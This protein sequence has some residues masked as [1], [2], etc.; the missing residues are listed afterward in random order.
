MEKCIVDLFSAVTQIDRRYFSAIGRRANREPYPQLTE[1]S[2]SAELF[3]RFKNI[4]ELPINSEYYNNLI[5]HY[6]ITKGHMNGRPDLVLHQAQENTNDQRLLIEVKTD[7]GADLIDDLN[8]LITATDNYLHF[9]NVALIIVNR[10][11]INTKQITSDFFRILD[12]ERR[13][14]IFLINIEILQNNKIDY[15]LFQFSQILV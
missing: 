14:K 13:K 11:F 9:D 6:D 1:A 7:A 4:I 2:F 12:F 8:K 5:L 3:H 15:N 10:Q